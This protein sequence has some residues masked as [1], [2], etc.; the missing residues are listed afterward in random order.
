MSINAI[1]NERNFVDRSL[2]TTIH[3]TGLVCIAELHVHPHKTLAR[4]KETIHKKNEPKYMNTTPADVLIFDV[5]IATNRSVDL[6][7]YRIHQ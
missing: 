3:G 1:S 4:M 7:V 6:Q 2:S 5:K